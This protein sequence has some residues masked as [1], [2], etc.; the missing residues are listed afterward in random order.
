MRISIKGKRKILLV[1]IIAVL[2]GLVIRAAVPAGEPAYDEVIVR[3]NDTLWTIAAAHASDRQNMQEYIYAIR[4]VNHI[5]DPGKLQTG[6]VIL[7]PKS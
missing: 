4:T 1:C 6:Q 7:I 3:N 5:E 2:G